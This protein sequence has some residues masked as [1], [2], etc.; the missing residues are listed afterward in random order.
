MPRS[1]TELVELLDLE[2]IDDNLFRA[3]QPD[4]RM[5]RVFGGQVAAQALVAAGRTVETSRVVNSLHAYFLR[6]GDTRVP[7]I[8]DVERTRDGHSFST[9]R[10][11]GRQHGKT[12]F[13]MSASFQQPEPGLEH[14]DVM[15]QAPAPEDVPTLAE[16]LEAATGRPQ[17][18]WAAEWA[19]LEV[20]L[21]G[22]SE[23]T[24]TLRDP[25]HP[26]RVRVWMRAAGRLPDDAMLQNCVLTY[27]SDLTLLGS[28]LVPHGTFI[29]APDLQTASLD[30]AI[31]FHRPFR[32][33]EWM[34]YDQ[35]S[36]SA[37]GARG[38]AT[39]RVF[40]TDG[41]LLASVVQEGL[42]RRR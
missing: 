20:R 33:D 16:T 36:P 25:E 12:I 30:H 7:I 29:G 13:S 3:R 24:G 9:R 11:I 4:T 41:R 15:P 39:G 5:Q 8:Y 42:I 34:L 1:L 28:T 21:A 18:A 10:V 35:I 32:A 14:A 31:W 26:A 6:P 22:A 17:T 37:S 23:P 27:A 2:D 19:A 38:L 40:S